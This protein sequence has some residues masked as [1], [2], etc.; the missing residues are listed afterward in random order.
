MNNSS[1]WMVGTEGVALCQWMEWAV[2]FSTKPYVQCSKPSVIPF[3]YFVFL[4]DF[5]TFP[6]HWLGLRYDP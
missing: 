5:P 2:L 6:I 3:A 1:Q 4:L